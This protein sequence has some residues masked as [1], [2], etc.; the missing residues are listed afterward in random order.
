VTIGLG[1]AAFAMWARRR[2]SSAEEDGVAIASGAI[3]GEALMGILI[4]LL[5]TTGVL[6][7]PR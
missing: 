5:L 1:A 4:A 6:A 3:T 7:A 2:A